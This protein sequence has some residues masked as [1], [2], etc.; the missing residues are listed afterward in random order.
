MVIIIDIHTNTLFSV[1]I[2][3]NGNNYRH[4]YNYTDYIH[5]LISEC[6]SNLTPQSCNSNKQRTEVVYSLQETTKFSWAKNP[7]K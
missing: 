3:T 1:Y 6:M 5:M 2:Q 4:T 7:R